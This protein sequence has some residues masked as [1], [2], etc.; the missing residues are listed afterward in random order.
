MKEKLEPKIC[1]HCGLEI[2]EDICQICNEQVQF[3]K[4]TFDE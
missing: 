2:I 4:E 3:E 1:I